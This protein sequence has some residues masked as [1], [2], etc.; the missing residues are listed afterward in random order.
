M[1]DS[2]SLVEAT[3]VSGEDLRR[4]E[5]FAREPFVLEGDDAATA[6]V[7]GTARRRAFDAAL[8][9]MAAGRDQPSIQWRREFSL[10]L[11]LERLL[12]QEEPRLKDGTVLSAHQ[13]DAL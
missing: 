9:E 10:V 1:A 6:L 4:A 12:A 3:P 5:E 2:T 13:V 11:G 7:P 8:A